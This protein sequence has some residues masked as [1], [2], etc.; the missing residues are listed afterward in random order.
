M[1]YTEQKKKEEIKL[2]LHKRIKKSFDK[3]K[4]LRILGLWK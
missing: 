4:S 3:K 2:S 1:P